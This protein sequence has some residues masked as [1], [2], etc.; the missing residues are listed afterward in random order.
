MY[1]EE[2]IAIATL[3]QLVGSELNT[4]DRNTESRTRS[5][6]NKLDPKSFLTKNNQQLYKKNANVIKHDGM[7]FH[8]GIDESL[9][10]SLYPDVHP[11]SQSNSPP[12]PPVGGAASAAV[13]TP[14]LS[15][16]TSPVPPGPDLSGSLAELIKIISSIDKTM[17]SI[18][19]NEKN[20]TKLI[21]FLTEKTSDKNT[22]K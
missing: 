7:N 11:T 19:K 9:V 16:A 1:N 6:A 15:I 14:L 21:T 10:Q 20:I 4:I 3:A 12:T 17:K 22:S 5:P 13:H 18:D 8:A 2:D